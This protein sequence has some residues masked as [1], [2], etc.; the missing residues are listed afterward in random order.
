M[1]LQRNGFNI[2]LICMT[3]QTNRTQISFNEGVRDCFNWD[4]NQVALMNGA[5]FWGYAV[6]Q[7]ISGIIMHEIGLRFSINCAIFLS[8]ISTF[9][10]PFTVY[11]GYNLIIF[12]RLITGIGQGFLWPYIQSIVAY[13][14]PENERS[15]HMAI[16]TCGIGLGPAIAFLLSGVFCELSI[17]YSKYVFGR[18]G[19]AMYFYFSGLI[20][21]LD[22]LLSVLFLTDTPAENKYIS[23]SEANYIC[24]HVRGA[25]KNKDVT[26]K[27]SINWLGILKSVTVWTF[28]SA[29]VLCDVGL[30]AVWTIIPQF[31]NDIIQFDITKNGLYNSLPYIFH[32]VAIIGTGFLSTYIISKRHWVSHSSACKMFHATGCI[33]SAICLISI[34]FTNSSLQ[35]VAILMLIVGFTFH[36][37]II[38]GGVVLNCND[39]AGSL[40]GVV[41]TIGNTASAITGFFVPFITAKIVTNSTAVQWRYAFIVELQWWAMLPESKLEEDRNTQNSDTN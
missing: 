9:L 16:I 19:W 4:T 17:P 25:T 27:I 31:M 13:W 14:S 26:T 34:S 15:V 2:E 7:A 11:G 6:S 36:G 35:A 28:L 5:F 20:G 30:Y 37:L 41:F 32:V 38:G 1:Y 39:F 29:L 10:I 18:N 21:L 22:L 8:S 33:G 24:S 40:S 3:C 12:L 23:K